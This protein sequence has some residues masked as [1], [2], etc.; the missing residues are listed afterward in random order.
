MKLYWYWYI[1]IS[2]FFSLSSH[3][4]FSHIKCNHFLT[5]YIA[6]TFFLFSWKLLDLQMGSL[7]TFQN[8]LTKPKCS[9]L[10]SKIS[11]F[12]V[13]YK[14]WTFQDHSVSSLA[15]RERWMDLKWKQFG[16]KRDGVG[17]GQW[18]KCSPH[19]SFCL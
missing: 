4:L 11:L 2:Q 3:F 15:L 10:F 12:G 8:I 16:A 6:Y 5:F 13:K 19:S 14:L 9:H 7:L 18:S 1:R 17:R